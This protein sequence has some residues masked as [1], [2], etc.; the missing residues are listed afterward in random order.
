MNSSCNACDGTG[1]L[2]CN[3]CG[4]TGGIRCF[5]CDGS[6]YI[7]T[8]FGWDQSTSKFRHDFMRERGSRPC[9]K[10]EGRGALPCRKCGVTGRIT[11]RKCNGTGIY[12][13]RYSPLPSQN[14]QDEVRINGTVKWYDASKGFGFITP[15]SG[16][17]DLHV[18]KK[19][20]QGVDEL[21]A[22]SRVE[23]VRRDGAKG[24]WAAFVRVV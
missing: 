12:T 16:G 11:C 10:C 4:G 5:K 14:R 15:D 22:G 2:I 3:N 9:H 7:A 20:L 1:Y 6:G 24:P 21:I 17:A 23:F 18:N 8:P 13:P 19:N